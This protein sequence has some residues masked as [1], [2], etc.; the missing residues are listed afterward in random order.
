MSLQ[1]QI[2]WPTVLSCKQL[3]DIFCFKRPSVHPKMELFD[4][5]RDV[6]N[7]LMGEVESVPALIKLIEKIFTDDVKGIMLSTIHKAK[8]LE[9]ERVFF[10]CPELIP[11]KYATQ[12]WQ[13]EQENHLR[14]VAITRA[15]RELIYVGG[16]EFKQDLLTK[17]SL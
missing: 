10:L 12:P 16:S 9:N 13:Y 15:K 11:S 3:S 1:C 5:R 2:E 6:I 4:Q 17:I 8:G 14:Y 7:C